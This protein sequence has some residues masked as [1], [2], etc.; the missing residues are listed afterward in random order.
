MHA[1]PRAM[2]L[3]L[4]CPKL[5]PFYR[6]FFFGWSVFLLLFLSS[7]FYHCYLLL[8]LPP[9]SL[10]VIHVDDCRLPLPF[11]FSFSN[12][13][14]PP[15]PRNLH[16]LRAQHP[17]LTTPPNHPLQIRTAPSRHRPQSDRRPR[18]EITHGVPGGHELLGAGTAYP[19]DSVG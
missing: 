18:H 2:E 11:F 13:T 15:G 10:R 6:R 16:C 17:R 19:W 7:T 4:T 3:V 9:F 12:A 5:R 1:L 14:N 8:Y